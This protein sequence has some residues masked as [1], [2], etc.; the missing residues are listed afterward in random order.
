[1]PLKM[2]NH[3]NRLATTLHLLLAL[4][5]CTNSNSLVADEPGD[6]EKRILS[7]VKKLA[8]DEWE[9]RGV[10]TKGL[11]KAAYFISKSFR[12]AG[13]NV[14]VAGGDA[15]QEF[16]ISDGARLG[17]VNTLK[18]SGP[19]EKTLDLKIGTDFEVCSFGGSGKIEGELIFAGY[20]IV[21]DDVM[22][23]DFEGIEVKDKIVIIMRRNPKQGDPHGPFA[24][25]HGISRHAG[26]TTKLS[27]AYSRGAKAVIFVNDPFTFRS[28]REQLQEQVDKAGKE[29][30]QLQNSKEAEEKISEAKSHLAQ[31][32]DLLKNFNSDPLMEFGYAGTRSGSSPP[33]VHAASKICNQLL[34]SALGMTLTE[35]EKKIDETGEPFSKSLDGWTASLETSLEII[36]IPVSNVIGVIE[37]EG[38]LKDETIVVGAHFDHLGFGGEGSLAPKSKEIHNGADDNGSGTAGLLELARRLGERKE[39]LP[40]RVV[41]IAFNGEERGLLGSAEYVDKPLY[42]LEKT[43]AML[44]MDMIG[45]LDENKL[46]IFG[47]GTS[48]VWD[49]YLDQAATDTELELVKK[50]EGFGPSDHAS[51]YGKKIPVLHFFTGIHDD[52][53]RPGDDWEKLNTAGMKTI[54]DI[55]ENV[56]VEVANTEK[57]PDY[58]HIPGA[59]SLARSGSR[60]YFGSIPDFGKE[61]EGYAISGVSPESPADKGGLKGGDVIVELAGRKIGGLD[62]FDLALREF[63]PGG[64]VTVVVLR[65]SEKL[66]LSVTLGTPRN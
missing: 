59:A 30:S 22:Y 64:K 5:C 61:V 3:K 51:F 46:T 28:E 56:T 11:N 33:T 19:Y 45:R 44:N 12:E 54:I 24:V 39:P 17:E 20:G 57:R 52:Y 4:V 47:T 49:Q 58:I 53:H 6:S 26:L 15:Y 27:R 14:T 29:L 43:V 63:P 10:G 37:G 9:G 31:V 25:G 36:R 35:I 2:L 1:M 13:L 16:E 50:K 55:V 18:L 8:A 32:Q 40:R 34:Q 42:S 41:F 38:P 23:N 7:D 48:T 21:A 66:K 60:P 65:D 62:D